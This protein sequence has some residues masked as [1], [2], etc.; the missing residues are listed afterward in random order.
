M[1]TMTQHKI[2][3]LLKTATQTSM[4]AGGL[5]LMVGCQGTKIDQPVAANLISGQTDQDQMNF[6]HE[7][8]QRPT[9][10]NNAAFHA[11]LLF[12]D[13]KDEQPNY[14]ARVQLLKDRK[15][16]PASFKDAADR[17]VQRGDLAVAIARALDIRGGVMMHLTGNNS[18]YATR[19]LVFK[20]LYPKSSEYQTFTGPEFVGII[21][22][23]DDYQ[24]IHQGKPQAGAQEVA[25]KGSANSKE[26]QPATTDGKATKN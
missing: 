17:A 6:W 21:G 10:D 19:E 2:W 9:V 15:M 22:R 23:M 13:G 25:S 1:I 18:R 14:E 20:G 4:L 7:L 12:V 16:L 5:L 3:K 26:A 11:L 8:A 24:R